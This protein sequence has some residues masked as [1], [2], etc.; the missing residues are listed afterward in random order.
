MMPSLKRGAT[1]SVQ[2]NA[3]HNGGRRRGC[4]G[5]GRFT[6]PPPHSVAAPRAQEFERLEAAA[7]RGPVASSQAGISS[8]WSLGGVDDDD[9]VG[10]L[11]GTS[12]NAC[13]D[14]EPKR[15]ENMEK[16]DQSAAHWISQ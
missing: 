1:F 12:A 4:E 15:T 16:K 7:G 14:D 8:T 5:D 10:M 11:A 6:E 2:G 13:Y 3:W 9:D